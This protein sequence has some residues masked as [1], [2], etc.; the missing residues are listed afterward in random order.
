MTTTTKFLR[1]V[2]LVAVASVAA[3]TAAL[4]QTT[5]LATVRGAFIGVSVGDL[6]ASVKW[7]AE[8]LGLSVIM[9]PPKI[10]KS[11]AVILQGGGLTVEL[12]H[13]D[14]AVPLRTAAPTIN[15]N[16]LVHGIF[17]SGIFV[18]DFDK[19]ISGLKERG[20]PIAMGPFPARADQPANA[21]IRDNEGNFIQIFGTR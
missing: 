13:H 17:K 3:T 4:A 16:Y 20:V 2:G 19:A 21:M 14:D 18:D 11:T 12:M 6:D 9:R 8:K 5:P 10:E 15:R 7:Y 1:V